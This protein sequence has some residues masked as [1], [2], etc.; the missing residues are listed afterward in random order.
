MHIYRVSI[1]YQLY[2]RPSRTSEI[3]RSE[4]A[5]C[6]YVTV[7]FNIDLLSSWVNDRITDPDL[8]RSGVVQCVRCG[9]Y[10][11]DANSERSARTIIDITKILRKS[12]IGRDTIVRFLKYTHKHNAR[13]RRVSIIDG[14]RA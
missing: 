12:A 10:H 7:L 8:I 2:L 14:K 1:A 3:Y 11:T 13:R 4:I 5:G 9:W 6:L